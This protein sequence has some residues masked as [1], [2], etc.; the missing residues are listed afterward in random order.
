M[1]QGSRMSAPTVLLVSKAMTSAA[2]HG[3]AR[4][5][6]HHCRV[7]LVTPKRWRSYANEACPEASEFEWIRLPTVMSGYNHFHLYR[8]LDTVIARVRP[9]LIHIDEEPW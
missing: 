3:K 5:L 8:G 9:Q 1:L 6:N 2:T 4:L 7:V